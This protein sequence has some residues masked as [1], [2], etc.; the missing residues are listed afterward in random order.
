MPYLNAIFRHDKLVKHYEEKSIEQI[1]ATPELGIAAF[2]RI[3]TSEDGLLGTKLQP[4]LQR[5]IW[6]TFL[7][8]QSSKMNLVRVKITCGTL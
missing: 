2:P 1:S 8:Y 4:L 6:E 3:T 7:K 5:E